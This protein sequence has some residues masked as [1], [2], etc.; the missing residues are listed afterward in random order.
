M[1]ELIE[2]LVGGERLGQV[3]LAL[4]ERRRIEITMSNRARSLCQRLE[5]IEGIALAGVD[6]SDLRA[7]L[8]DR[9]LERRR[10]AVDADHL[11]RHRRF[12]ARAAPG[13]HVAEHI[14]HARALCARIC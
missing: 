12:A 11:A 9:E 5:H 14:E 1:R 2:P 8:L 3:L 4:G 7:A 6:A 10:G 13:A